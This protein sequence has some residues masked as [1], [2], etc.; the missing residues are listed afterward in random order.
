VQR[1]R[2]LLGDAG[3][4]CGEEALGGQCLDALDHHAADHLQRGGGTDLARRDRAAH[5]QFVDQQRHH[6][7]RVRSG[8]Q[9][10]GLVAPG[11]D[12][13]QDRDVDVT[14][15]A[16][17]QARGRLLAAGRD[18]IDVEIVGIAGDVRRDRLRGFQARRRGH[19]RN[20]DV[21]VGDRVGGRGREARAHFLAGLFEPRAFILPEQDIPR[22]DAL[23]AGF[24]QARRDRLAGFA[25]ADEAETGLVAVHFGSASLRWTRASKRSTF[26]TT[27]L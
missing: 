1:G 3:A 20:D 9:E 17:E 23:D 15:R 22:R 26:T 11:V 8:E 5:L 7:L 13:R 2:D 4:S 19:G 12:R 16:F 21:G 27:R 14:R 25:E 10:R 6:G 24:A 18:R